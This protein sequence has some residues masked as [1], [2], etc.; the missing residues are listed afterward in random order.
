MYYYK[1]LS[2]PIATWL[3]MRSDGGEGILAAIGGAAVLLTICTLFLLE[4]SMDEE[5]REILLVLLCVELVSD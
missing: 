5:Y 3:I 4:V 2:A 1:S